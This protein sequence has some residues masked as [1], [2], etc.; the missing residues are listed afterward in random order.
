MNVA[1]TLID[2][3][4]RNK[5]DLPWRDSQDPYTVWLSEVILQQ[6][7]VEQGRAYY[8]RFLER[9]PAVKDLAEANENEVLRTWQGLG[10]YS[11]ARNLHKTAQ[12]VHKDYNG[13]F[14][15]TYADLIGLRGV[16]PYT[17]AAIASFCFGEKKAVLDGNVIRVLGRLFGV[18]IPADSVKGK[19]VYQEIADSLIPD[20]DPA[21]F[22]QAIMEFG[23]LWCT[24]RKPL[25][26]DCPFRGECQAL[27]AGAV[28][29]YPVKERKTK[30]QE[31]WYYYLFLSHRGK[32]FVRK[33][34]HNGIWKG[35]HD[36]PC[37]ESER[38]LD[39]SELLDRFNAD[40]S[41]QF[42]IVDLIEPVCLTHLLSHR[43][44][45]AFFFAIDRKIMWKNR[46]GEFMEINLEDLDNIG[47]PR[48]I[49]QYL[50]GRK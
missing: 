36:F 49:D 19:K 13:I 33:R 25:C 29:N 46:P 12:T 44:I 34:A 26:S 6:T 48:L 41:L 8:H 10:Y 16:G 4:G 50:A 24:P 42:E 5:R 39:P 22:N 2:W 31:V 30:V 9:F 37:I 20:A 11:R 47:I 45:Q 38:Q 40:L 23:A 14:P 27:L 3:Y 32:T 18:E 35:L 17:A 43:R 7:R 21:T 28:Q 1:E 15:R